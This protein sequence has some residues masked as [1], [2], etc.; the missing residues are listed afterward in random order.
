[1]RVGAS[2]SCDRVNLVEHDHGTVALCPRVLEDAAQDQFAFTDPL[3]HNLRTTDLVVRRPGLLRN[4]P[5]QHRLACPWV[6][7]EQHSLDW[8]STE[9]LEQLTALQLKFNESLGFRDDVAVPGE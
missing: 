3:G 1:M 6:A 2:L 7:G 8:S 4:D 5:R 9:S